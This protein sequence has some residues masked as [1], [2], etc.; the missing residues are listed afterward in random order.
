M[1]SEIE[2]FIRRKWL[3]EKI[4]KRLSFK[5]QRINMEEEKM[6]NE[7]LNKSISGNILNPNKTFLIN[8][9]KSN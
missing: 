4:D 2:E 6:K 5:M 9:K 1:P 3:I 8:F 7:E